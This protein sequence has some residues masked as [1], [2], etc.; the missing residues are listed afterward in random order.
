MTSLRIGQSIAVAVALGMLP[1][2]QAVAVDAAGGKLKVLIVTGQNNHDWVHTTPVM[3]QILEESGRFTVDVSTTPAKGQKDSEAWKKWQPEFKGHDVVLFD[4]NGQ[5]W[6]DEVCAS[7][8]DYM[9]KGGGLVVVHGADNPFSKWKEFNEMIGVGGWGGRNE[10]S[11]PMLYWED[12]KIVR[13]MSPGA[14]GTHGPQTEFIVDTRVVDHPIT[15]GLPAK[16]LHV[17]D[18]LYSKLRGPATNLTVLATSLS[19]Q[20][21]RNEPV[22]MVID[23]GKGRVFHTVLGHSAEQMNGLGFQITLLRG[24]EWAASGKVT[25]DKPPVSDLKSDIAVTRPVAVPSK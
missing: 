18:E 2:A 22:L 13:D 20:T 7:F 19:G 5:D 21:Q 24:T 8:T 14:G 15:K 16:W 1:F 4:Y 12:G 25:I 6:P 17:K 9:I 11:G 3:K 10:K 23:F